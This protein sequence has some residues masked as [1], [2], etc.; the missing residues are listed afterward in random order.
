MD[1]SKTINNENK[2]P[3]PIMHK[4][5][6]FAKS[7]IRIIGYAI[8]PFNITIAAVVLVISELL[9]VGEELV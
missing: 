8:L 9:G 2:Y 6:S 5:V 7:A 4:Y 3:D 1:N